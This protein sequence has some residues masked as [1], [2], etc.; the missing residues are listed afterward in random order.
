MLNPFVTSI[1][2]I[3]TTV[4][5]FQKVKDHWNPQKQQ[6]DSSAYVYIGR[7]NKRYNL[8]QSPWNNPFVIGKDGDRDEVLAKYRAHIIPLIEGVPI[9]SSGHVARLALHKLR[10]KILVCWCK[11][12]ACHGDIL[13]ELLNEYHPL[14]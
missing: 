12:L 3:P 10:G 8:P 14:P 6:W 4:A 13:I 5:K 11:P 2:Q 7:F 1:R 9:T